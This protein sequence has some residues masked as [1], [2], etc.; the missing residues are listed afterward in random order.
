MAS[1][2]TG[3]PLVPPT[4][5]SICPRAYHQ[6]A[7]ADVHD[8]R[9]LSGDHQRHDAVLGE[10]FYFFAVFGGGYWLASTSRLGLKLR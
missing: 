7:V 10:L 3:A 8:V 9:Q 6:D 2:V 1:W 5:P 4:S